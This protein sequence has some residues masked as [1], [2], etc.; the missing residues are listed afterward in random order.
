[1][2][3]AQQQILKGVEKVA[4]CANPGT[5][6]VFEPTSYPILTSVDKNSI[7]F[8]A[9]EYGKGR[10]FCVPH[11][12][13]LENF[14]RHP[15]I[16]E[17]LWSNIKLWLTGDEQFR[18]EDIHNLEEFNAVSD[19]PQHVK[20]VKWIGTVNKTELFINQL[21]KKF[22]SNGGSVLCGVCP[23][24]IFK[25]FVWQT[26]RYKNIFRAKLNIL[27]AQRLAQYFAW[28]NFG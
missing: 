6:V 17:P 10:V 15:Q 3:Q 18:D 2:N 14:G 5:L 24:G 23:W 22:V 21:L 8:A 12:S 19:I 25:N 20:L 27:I 7:L 1:M 13:Y 16:F 11:E 4:K 28:K 9:A 26:K